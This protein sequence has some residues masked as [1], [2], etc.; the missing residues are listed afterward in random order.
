MTLDPSPSA[1]VQRQLDAYNAKDIVAWLATYAGDAQQ[2]ELPGKLLASGHEE[3]EARGVERFA[4]PRLHARLITRAV[5]GPVVID[6]EQ[7]TRTFPDG[8]GTLELVCIYMVSEGRIQHASF[9]FGPRLDG[10]TTTRG[11]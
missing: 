9:V 7:V 1:V 4:D 5:M 10:Q 3:I 2:Y 8:P 6:H 11:T